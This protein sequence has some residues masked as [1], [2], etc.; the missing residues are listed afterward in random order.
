MTLK[1][2]IVGAINGVMAV[3][4]FTIRSDGTPGIPTTIDPDLTERD[5]EGFRAVKVFVQ[6]QSTDVVDFFFH[7]EIATVNLAI[8]AVKDTRDFTLEAGQGALATVGNHFE[9]AEGLQTSQFQI[10]SILGDVLTV[11]SLI[12]VAYTT[13][14]KAEISNTNMNVDGSGAPRIF[15]LDPI[16]TQQWDLT[17]I[18]VVIEAA[19]GGSSMDFTTFGSIVGGI[20][21][22]CILR[23]VNGLSNNLFTW[24]TN[25]EFINRSFDRIFE[26]NAGNTRTAFSSRYTLGGQDKHGVVMRLSGKNDDKAQIIIQD[27]LTSQSVVRVIGQGHETQITRVQP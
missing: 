6:D 4:P 8:D 22:G 24:K 19:G 26:S 21:N 14:A 5:A 7:E 1:A 13:Q 23:R 20:T 18:I 10:I 12:D 25:G 9:I 17:R 27:N 15:E 3:L 16:D 2:Q 11:G